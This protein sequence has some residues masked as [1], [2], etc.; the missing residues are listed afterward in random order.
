MNFVCEIFWYVG[1]VVINTSA[2]AHQRTFTSIFQSHSSII[3]NFWDQQIKECCLHTYAL[4][5][6][7]KGGVQFISFIKKAV[8]WEGCVDILRDYTIWMGD[9]GM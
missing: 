6:T 7:K 4:T 1:F 3:Y 5:N 2:P 9:H 8:R